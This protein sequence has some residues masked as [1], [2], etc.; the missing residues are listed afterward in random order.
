MRLVK[1][2]VTLV[3]RRLWPSLLRL[4][5]R[6]P[7]GA[8]MVLHQEHTT[9]GAHRTTELGLQEWVPPDVRRAAERL[10]EDEALE[11]LPDVLRPA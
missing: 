7:A 3:H 11:R 9:T 2:K 4:A 10:S 5:D 8:T 6:F 1:G